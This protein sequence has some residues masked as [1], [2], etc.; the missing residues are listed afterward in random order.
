MRVV[1]GENDEV[2][3]KLCWFLG[4]G[5]GFKVLIFNSLFVGVEWDF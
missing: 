1:L 3:F 4:I 5:G 2:G